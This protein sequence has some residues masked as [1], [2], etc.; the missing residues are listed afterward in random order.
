MSIAFLDLSTENQKGGY[1]KPDQIKL[2]KYKLELK[3]AK[4]ELTKLKA[5]CLKS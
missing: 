3:E 4:H 2:L 5:G 1:I